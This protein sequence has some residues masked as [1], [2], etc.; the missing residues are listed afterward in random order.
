[1]S[2]RITKKRTA[3]KPVP[4]RGATRAQIWEE[5]RLLEAR[6]RLQIEADEARRKF[7]REM[8]KTSASLIAVLTA[9]AISAFLICFSQDPGAREAGI[10]IL[11][12]T[13]YAGNA[14]YRA[15]AGRLK[16]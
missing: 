4:R 15:H 6:A 7:I 3:P 16:R 8:I 1:M 5:E 12:L 13:G 11:G 10:A 14:A 2:Q 9:C